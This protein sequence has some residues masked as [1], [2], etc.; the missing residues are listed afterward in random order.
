MIQKISELQKQLDEKNHIIA[1]HEADLM[2]I[3]RMKSRVIAIVQKKKD[4]DEAAAAR[5][6]E[7]KSPTKE[8][9]VVTRAQTNR[10]GGDR[11]EVKSDGDNNGDDDEQ[12]DADEDKSEIVVDAM[13]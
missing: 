3:E 1:D 9:T 8:V 4:D 5:E 2:E 11:D 6:A 13:K 7:I 10:G 12:N